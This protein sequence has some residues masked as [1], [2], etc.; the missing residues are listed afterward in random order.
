MGK[1]VGTGEASGW[2]PSDNGTV[3]RSRCGAAVGSAAWC[4]VGDT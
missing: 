4:E 3:S 1:R 2:V